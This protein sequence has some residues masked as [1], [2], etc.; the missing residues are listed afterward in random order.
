MSKTGQVKISLILAV[1]VVSCTSKQVKYDNGPFI[2]GGMEEPRQV[3]VAH[4]EAATPAPAAVSTPSLKIPKGYQ[5]LR[6]E[7]PSGLWINLFFPHHSRAVGRPTDGRLLNGNCIRESGPGYIH[8]GP[9]SCA[10]DQTVA[11]LMFALGRLRKVYPGTPPLVIGS[12]S[13][14]GGGRIPPHHSHQNGLDVDVGYIPVRDMGLKAFKKLAPSDIDF[15]RTFYFMAVLLSTG[16]VKY[17]FV[18]YDLQKYLY[19]AARNMGYSDD[20]LGLIFQYP[21]QRYKKKGIIRYSPG[22]RDHFHVR[23]T[24]PEG[25]VDCVE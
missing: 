22:H 20:Q 2:V 24:C 10:T 23:F 15:D 14:P 17:I 16:K 3:I 4:P 11:L 18:D 7:T 12:L 19:S 25:D 13:A 1:V 8:F 9:N 6:F 5:M 21:A